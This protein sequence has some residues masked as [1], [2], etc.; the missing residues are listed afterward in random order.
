MKSLAGKPSFSTLQM[1][2][3]QT[4]FLDVVKLKDRIGVQIF[5]IYLIMKNLADKSSFS[6]LQMNADQ[7]HRL[8]VV[9]LKDMIGV[10]RT[11]L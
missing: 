10:Q 8:G 7:T 6:T 11:R 2:V 5:Y 3:D 4:H 9:K 1:N